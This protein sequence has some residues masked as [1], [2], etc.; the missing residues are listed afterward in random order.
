[1]TDSPPLEVTSDLSSSPPRFGFIFNK[2]DPSVHKVDLETLM[3]L[4]TIGLHH[5]GCVPQAMAH[6]HLGGYFF[7]QCRQDSP[8][9]AARQLLVDSVTDSVVG[10]NGDVTGTPHTSPDGR[11]IVSTAADS[12]WLHVQEITVQGEIQTLYDLQINP[13]ISD[14]AFQRSFTESNQYNIYAAL[15]TEPDL[16]F[17]ELSTGKVGTLKNLKEPPTGPPQPWG[18]ARRIVRDSGLFGQYLLTPAQE[19]LFLINGRQNTLRCEVSGIKGGTTVVWV[20]EV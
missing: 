10:P 5:H 15:H 14:L 2:S 11:F 6:T 19:S 9:S 1:M 12:P 18:G 3:P 17:L 4:K 13:G 16:L 7:I 8:A 20:G